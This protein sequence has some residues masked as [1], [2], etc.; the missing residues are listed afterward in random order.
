MMLVDTYPLKCLHLIFL[1]ARQFKTISNFTYRWEWS[2]GR[3]PNDLTLYSISMISLTVETSKKRNKRCRGLGKLYSI[4]E[5]CKPISTRS[6]SSYVQNRKG[7]VEEEET[8]LAIIPPERNGNKKTTFQILRTAGNKY[9][10]PMFIKVSGR[11][12]NTQTFG[13]NIH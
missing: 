5:P 13:T 8:L 4:P 2:D 7:S 9:L 6:N 11:Q 1:F 3:N 10:Y 12:I